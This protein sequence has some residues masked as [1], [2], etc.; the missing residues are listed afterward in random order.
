[1]RVRIGSI[2]LVPVLS[3]LCVHALIAA[4]TTAPSAAQPQSDFLRLIDKGTTGS[5]LET[6]DVAYRNADGAT[7][8]LVAAVHVGEHEYFDGLNQNFKLRDAV[9]YEMV[10]PRDV[11][12]PAKPD[13]HVQTQSG[14]SQIQRMMKDVLGLE[15]QLDV[16]DYSA[17]NF[18]H[19][20]L[21]AET[22]QKMQADRGES[23]TSLALQA[24]VKAMS[25]PAAEDDKAQPA[26][27]MDQ[28]LEDLVKMFTRPDMER[29]LKLRFARQMVDLENNPMGPNALN[30]TVL[31]TERN[32]AAIATLDKT[33]AS[34]KKDIAIFYG[35]A[36][37]PELSQ[38]LAD[39]GFK[40]V[41]TEWRLAWDLT[42]R[43]D[44]PSAVEKA[45]ME[46]LK[47]A[48]EEDDKGR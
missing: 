26:Q 24:L 36:H 14:V 42:I 5:R 22:F 37:M 29:Q 2:A 34:G 19:A 1:M 30:G 44:A 46:M 21:D 40:P 47:S 23:F 3:I 28:A 41:A 43:P 45:L 16:V 31:L 48:S 15:F 33:L 18:V 4:P 20:D 32:K 6:A 11:A 39:R 35:A 12:M 13:E 27:D 7:V 25:Q 8:H 10:K 38:L 9:L 17:P